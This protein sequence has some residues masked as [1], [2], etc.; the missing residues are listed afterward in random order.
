V[1]TVVYNATPTA[2]RFHASPKFVRGIMGPVGSGKS[3]ACCMELLRRGSEQEPE[4]E[5]GVRKTR[6]VVVRNTYRELKDTTV[7]TWLEWFPEA[8]FGRFNWSDMSQRIRV[9]DMEMEVLFRALDRE[10]DVKKLLSMEVT[11]GWINE[12]REIPKG[13]VDA[14]SDRV[15]RYPSMKSGVRCTWSGVIMDTNPPDDD[16]WWHRLAEEETPEG[17]EFFRQPGGLV[18]VADGVFEPNPEAENIARFDSLGNVLQAGIEPD[19]YVKRRAGKALEHIRCYYCGKYTFV[20]DGRAIFPE[21]HHNIHVV[22]GLEPVRGIA[23]GVGIDFGLTPAAVLGQQLPNGRMIIVDELVTEDMG[24][25]R[26][27]GLLLPM[28]TGQYAG[29]EVTAPWGDPA[30][31][32]R[33]Q[34]DERTPFE[35]LR[36]MGIPAR[37]SPVPGNDFTI[38]REA[39][40]SGLT[41]LIDGKPALI[42]SSKCKR[43]IKALAGGYCFRR[44]AVGGERYADKPD[45]GMF[46]HV[47][48]AAQYLLCGFGAGRA[49]VSRPQTGPRQ[50]EADF[51]FNFTTEKTTAGGQQAFAD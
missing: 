48:E 7:K 38:R 32:Q 21:F 34:T 49:L 17:W 24:C 27:G 2:A 39:V 37:P 30:G 14:L 4:P 19:Y 47:A 6:F 40:A 25:L 33:A 35:I 51:S 10:A 43:L 11:G 26:F 9:R 8:H 50:Q 1:A 28:L 5:T 46:S 36:A 16:H 3:T 15:G 31:E 41:R 45:K 22:D 29:F 18:E 42:I 20:A 12:A 44:L 13:I 23:L